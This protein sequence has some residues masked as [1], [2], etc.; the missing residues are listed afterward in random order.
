MVIIA[1]PMARFC[2]V[3]ERLVQGAKMTTSTECA[4]PRRQ[5]AHVV[6]LSLGISITA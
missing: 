1:Q 5:G 3:I 2:R 4:A 6:E